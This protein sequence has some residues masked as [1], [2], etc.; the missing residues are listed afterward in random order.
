MLGKIPLVKGF[1]II[2]TKFSQLCVCTLGL[3]GPYRVSQNYNRHTCEPFCSCKRRF[4]WISPVFVNWLHSTPPKTFETVN[5]YFAVE[6]ADLHSATEKE[7]GGYV[8]KLE[9]L[10]QTSL[11]RRDKK[12][13]GLQF[14]SHI[15]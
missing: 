2:F 10:I 5:S 7:K 3:H 15:V 12:K 9:L 11:Q 8:L 6:K 1:H 4:L 14:R 13:K